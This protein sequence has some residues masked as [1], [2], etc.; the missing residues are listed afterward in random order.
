M[1]NAGRSDEGQDPEPKPDEEPIGEE[2]SSRQPSDPESPRPSGDVA[3]TA[4]AAV[5]DMDFVGSRLLGGPL[6][7]QETIASVLGSPTRWFDP[8]PFM[9]KVPVPDLIGPLLGSDAFKG[10]FDP[11]PIIQAAW[12]NLDFSRVFDPGPIIQAAWAN[13]DFSPLTDHFAELFKGFQRIGLP[14]NVAGL[15]HVTIMD[16]IDVAED[17]ITLYL[18]P[19]E[20]TAEAL[21]TAGDVAAR[22]AVLGR[23]FES[24]LDDCDAVL[25]RCV[26][27]DT[28]GTV[29]F[30][31]AAIA[32]ARAGHTEAAQALA[33]NVLD[34]AITGHLTRASR[35]YFKHQGAEGPREARRAPDPLVP[36]CAADLEGSPALHAG[37]N[38]F[39]RPSPLHAARD[40]PWRL[41]AA[42]LQAQHRPVA[43]ARDELHRCAER[44]LG[45]TGR[46]PALVGRPK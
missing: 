26:A 44:A 29:V 34:S 32:A 13:L 42:V 2:A 18:V 4:L 22:R 31:R 24:I 43:D 36:R 25:D 39:G 41:A 8:T 38:G 30:T 27:A 11:G 1:E 23:S 21:I 16:V 17:G 7:S 33:A 40:R 14:S 20:A 35:A 28:R 10:L 12:A 3:G 46:T 37:H 5:F 15:D 19:R 6:F 9:P 45:N